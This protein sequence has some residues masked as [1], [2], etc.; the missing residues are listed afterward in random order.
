MALIRSLAVGLRA[1]FRRT[2]ADAELDAELRDYLEA[3]VAEKTK[4]GMSREEAVRAARL[5]IGSAD[6]V[7]EEVRAVGW[8]TVLESFWQDIRFA[9]RMMRKNPGFTAIAIITL[10]L[11]IGANT[12]IFSVVN[13]VLLQPMPY[14]QA[15]RL[16]MIWGENKARG[17]DLD[18]V[19]YL[20]YVDWKSQNRVFERM[21]A[22]TDEMFTMTGAG[23]PVALIG[24]Q[25]SPDFFDVLGVP[26]LLG[27]TFAPDEDRPGTNHVAVLNYSLWNTRFGGDASIVGKTIT[28]DGQ[29]YTVIGVM[30]R[31]FQHPPSVQIW[32]PLTIDA[33]YAKDRGIR[34]LRVMARLKPGVTL[35]QAQVAM[36]TIAARLRTAYPTSNK[37]YDVNIET[38]RHM[39]SGDVRPALLVLLCSVALV[40]LIA[41][42]NIANLLLSR[43]VARHREIA[44]RAALG[45]SRF[46]MIRQFLTESVLLALAGGALGLLI[47]YWGAHAL[48]AMF[49]S[50]ISNLS[51]PRIDAIPIDRWVLGFAM[52]ASLLTGILF[53]LAPALEACRQSPSESLKESGRT[54]AGTHGKRLRNVFVIAEMAL[55][56]VL[57]TAAGLMIRSFLHLVRADLGFRPD[58]VLSLRVLLPENKYKTDAQKVAFSDGVLERVQSLPGV[59]AAGTVT[60][61]PLSGWWG[62]REVSV[63]G[64]PADPINKNPR[65][66]WGS[67]S[68]NYF[69]AMNIPLLKGR[70]FTPQDNASNADAAILSASLARRLWPNDDPLGRQINVDGFSKPRQVVGVVGDVYQLGVGVQ[71]NGGHS[72][73]KSEIYVPYDQRPSHLLCLAIRT[74]ADPLGIARAVQ[75]KIWS[76]DKQQAVSFVETMDQLASETVVLQRASMILLGVFAGLALVLASIGIYGVISYSA[77]RRT[78]E[79]GIRI[80]LGA[81]AGDVLRLVVGEGLAL[82]LTGVA[83][84]M[85]GAFGLTRFLSSLLYGVRAS[86]PAT[87]VAVPVVLICVALTACYI[88][89]RR[90]T[91]VDPMVALRYE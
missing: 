8:E 23:E 74:A 71:P 90:A 13:T 40:L 19:S 39:T 45:A 46:R 89:A 28:L 41:C 72:D 3:A 47:A 70:Y 68:P 6:A 14:K 63:S 11:G 27:R 85:A 62:T 67:V 29:S 69:R 12:A 88:P 76:V 22:S 34:W 31:T 7:K 53:G 32:T 33:A 64:R 56:L 4:D 75:S 91:R 18:L 48:V 24:Y 35:D 16:V 44:I 66:V 50:T 52:L 86:D 78:H 57:L 80:A 73:V 37:D 15:D 1:M 87:F 30:P 59:E 25:F 51:I 84:G 20:D 61:L 81:G 83:I 21:G 79:I 36:R 43:A 55:S 49:P 58:H 10:A 38:L 60:F 26:P 9:L 2:K 42:A 65:P 77:S 82:T 17:Y 54:G 5:E